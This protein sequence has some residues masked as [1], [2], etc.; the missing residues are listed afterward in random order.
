MIV[1]VCSRVNDKELLEAIQD[2]PLVKY[3]P[4]SNDYVTDSAQVYEYVKEKLKVGSKCANCELFIKQIIRDGIDRNPSHGLRD[5]SS[6][7]R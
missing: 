6:D 2:A 4:F 5:N 7:S 1:C 3:D